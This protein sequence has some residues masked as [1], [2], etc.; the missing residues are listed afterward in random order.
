MPTISESVYELKKF[1]YEQAV[2]DYVDGKDSEIVFQARLFTL[3]YCGRDIMV[4]VS[5]ANS[6]KTEKQA[7]FEQ[8]RHEKSA[9]W[10]RAHTK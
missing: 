1:K 6:M 7:T 9:D 10:L 8:I 4:E 5:L 2:K 3:G